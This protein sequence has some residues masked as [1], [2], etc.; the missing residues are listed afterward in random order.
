MTATVDNNEESCRTEADNWA[1]KQLSQVLM[2]FSRPVACH[3]HKFR[4]P[5]RCIF[6]RI[7]LYLS[8]FLCAVDKVM[9]CVAVVATIFWYLFSVV[10]LKL[11]Q[12]AFRHC[13][14]DKVRYVVNMHEIFTA[15]RICVEYVLARGVRCLR[16]GPWNTRRPNGGIKRIYGVCYFWPVGL[17]RYI[18][19]RRENEIKVAYCETSVETLWSI[20]LTLWSPAWDLLRPSCNPALSITLVVHAFSTLFRVCV[21]ANITLDFNFCSLYSFWCSSLISGQLSVLLSCCPALLYMPLHFFTIALLSK[22]MNELLTPCDQC[23]VSSKRLGD[24]SFNLLSQR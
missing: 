19:N 7:L 1:I 17:S 23:D 18:S 4:Q 22:W 16:L 21:I 8:R 11:Y 24:C 15:R 3:W 5:W 13:T 12:K 2:V 14:S 6:C 9:F 20:Y 10:R